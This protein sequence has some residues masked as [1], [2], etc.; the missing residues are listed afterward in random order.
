MFHWY[1]CEYIMA[2]VALNVQSL[3][4]GRE[5]LGSI[6]MPMMIVYLEI[7]IEEECKDTLEVVC[8]VLW[9]L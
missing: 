1:M 7:V 8:C 2:S 6:S 4:V 3:A 9:H 5:V